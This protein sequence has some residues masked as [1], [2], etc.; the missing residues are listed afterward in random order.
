MWDDVI[1]TV[2]EIAVDV[3]EAVIT[4]K[5]EKKKKVSQSC[6]AET[7]CNSS[8]RLLNCYVDTHVMS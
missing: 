5:A 3:A 4:D 1:E 2:I 7:E 8:D 6:D